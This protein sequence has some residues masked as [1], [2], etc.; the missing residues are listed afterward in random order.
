MPV[1]QRYHLH[2]CIVRN[3]QPEFENALQLALSDKYFLT[4]DLIASPSQF[5][6]YTKQQMES[7]DCVLFVLG[8]SY[9]TLSPS[10]V[11][12]LHLSYVYASTKKK[13]MIAL[14]RAQ[15]SMTEYSRQRI[16]LASMISKDMPKTSF[17]FERTQEAILD[18]QRALKDMIANNLLV[19]WTKQEKPS[20]IEKP[21][22]IEKKPLLALSV[23]KEQIDLPKS[24][25]QTG[26]I[27][28]LSYSAHGYQDGN[29]HDI[30]ATHTFTWG[31][32]LE[33]LKQLPQPFSNESMLKQLNDSLK[34]MA[35]FE[36]KKVLPNVHAVARCQISAEDFH[37]IRK[38]LIENHWI[39]SNKEERSI[40]ELWQV[41]PNL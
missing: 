34:P 12:F 24:T 35:L 27:L 19:G 2:V 18:C 31:D 28:V 11:S 21:L 20:I 26:D 29:L 36:A 22:A 3:E 17:T 8:A 16:D 9:G 13:P 41:N 10:G 39:I 15:N 5:M 30:T 4:W 1:K 33:L 7:C 32:V 37:W 14:I 23:K 25:L 40:R 6:D 38:Q